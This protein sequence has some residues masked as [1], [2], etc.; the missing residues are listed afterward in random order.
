MNENTQNACLMTTSIDEEGKTHLTYIPLNISADVVD[1]FLKNGTCTN[2]QAID[3]DD[4]D[5]SEEAFW[6]AMWADLMGEND[7][8]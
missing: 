4:V 7:G 2:N 8:E 6:A 5:C 1:F 3:F